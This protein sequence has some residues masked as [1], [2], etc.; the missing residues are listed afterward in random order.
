ME[1]VVISAE[2]RD[3]SGKGV[4]RSLRRSERIPAVVY[5]AG[6]SHPITLKRGEIVGLIKSSAGA[7]AIVD[8]RFPDGQSRLALLKDYQLDPIKGELLHTDFFE[9]SL[10]EEVK[11]S[12]G[13][14]LSGEPES[15][16][17]DG[18]ILQY[19]L[20]KV[21]V[22]CL[23]DRIPG[24]IEVDVSGLLMGHALHVGDISAPEG[25]KILTEKDKLLAT[26][27][28]PAVEKVAVPVEA[29]VEAAAE[30]Q[31]PEVIKKGKEKEEDKE[32]KKKEKK[33]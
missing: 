25:V 4:A 2:V 23:P 16:K 28:A 32:E 30:A 7:R 11:V 9:V 5:R 31:Q 21:E 13:V 27:T 33:A 18:A 3:K 10:S 15:V 17:R 24:H 8:L 20:R 1:K 19:G 22:E 26:V 14:V 6:Q 12:V 29:A